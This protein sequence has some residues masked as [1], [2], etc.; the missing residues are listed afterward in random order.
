MYIKCSREQYT[1]DLHLKIIE[2]IQVQYDMHLQEASMPVAGDEDFIA[3]ETTS[4]S[5]KLR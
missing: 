4:R 1:M 2:D 5:S 3:R